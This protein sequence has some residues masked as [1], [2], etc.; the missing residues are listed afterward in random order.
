[1]DVS[2][3][4]GDK[5]VDHKLHMLVARVREK[6][7]QNVEGSQ[8]LELVDVG[9]L[10]PLGE[11]ACRRYRPEC[12]GGWT[13]KWQSHVTWSSHDAPQ[14]DMI[15]SVNTHK[16]AT[17]QMKWA[18]SGSQEMRDHRCRFLPLRAWRCRKPKIL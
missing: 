13:T 8:Q 15:L 4:R 6:R 2:D 9:A 10:V 1:M 17:G 7:A 14:P 5:Q 11:E 16:S 3:V 18:M 12:I